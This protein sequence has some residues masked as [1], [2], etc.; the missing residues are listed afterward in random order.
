MRTRSKT[1]PER[2]AGDLH[3]TILWR[4]VSPWHT[5]CSP[6][7]IRELAFLLITNPPGHMKRSGGFSFYSCNGADKIRM[8]SIAKRPVCII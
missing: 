7:L 2:K 8:K 6:I 3:D 5:S 1:A 4:T